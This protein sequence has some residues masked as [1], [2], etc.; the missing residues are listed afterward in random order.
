MRNRIFIIVCFLWCFKVNSQQVS[1]YTQW[2]FNHFAINP[3]MAGL[4]NCVDLRAGYRLQWAGFEG[5]PKTALFTVNTPIN[6]RRKLLSSPYHGLGLK[7]E[8]DAMGH[9]KDLSMSL[10]YAAHFPIGRDK[11]LSFGI[12]GGFQQFGFDQSNVSTI[13]PDNA[14]ANSASNFL[15]PLVSFGTWYN[16]NNYFVGAAMD[17]IFRNKWEDVGFNSRFGLHL[18]LTAGTRYQI[19]ELNTLLPA[20][21]LRIPPSGP[22]G[23]DLNLMVDFSDRFLLGIGYRNTDAIMALARFKMNNFSVGY[24]FDFITSD[25][26]G[27]NFHTHEISVLYN[28]CR[29]NGISTSACPLFE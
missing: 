17:Q 19:S 18:K 11:R 6:V 4:K 27:G 21:M 12:Q 2:S 26:R 5:A 1:Q 24:S 9:F 10:A 22:L 14:V 23:F 13:D 16:S 20:V 15:F 29:N 3:A 28:T 7:L 8:R 25:I